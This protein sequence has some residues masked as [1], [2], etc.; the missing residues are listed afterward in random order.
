MKRG[1]FLKKIF[2]KEQKEKKS[3]SSKNYFSRIKNQETWIF[4]GISKELEAKK[5]REFSK[6]H[7][8]GPQDQ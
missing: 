8:Q 3:A 5:K 1:F 2:F 7:F 6:L 4:N